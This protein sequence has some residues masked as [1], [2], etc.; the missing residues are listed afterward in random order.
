MSTF[1]GSIKLTGEEEYK[2]ALQTIT[3]NL[4]LMSST[5]KS[6]T[7][8]FNSQDKSI[9]NTAQA[10]KQLN[11]TI[12]Q[13]QQAI[14]VAK[15]SLSGYTIEMQKQSTIHNQLN[16][17]YKN[18]VLE[19][20]R[21]KK[22]SGETS[23]EYKKQAQ[24]VDK[25]EN[26]LIDSQI[27]L[28]DNKQAM[29]SLKKEISSSQKVI[30]DAQN[31]LD[32]LG[33]ELDDTEESA[34]KA[35]D[36]FTVFKGVVSDL[37]SKAIQGAISSV[38]KL[39][40][41]LIDLGK[42][43]ISNYADYEQL[44]GGV[45][46]LFKE[47]SDIVQGYAEQAY[48]TAGLSANEYMETVT[49][50]SASLLQGLGGDTK[51]AAEIAD[52]AIIDMSDNAN[53]MGTSMEMIQN[54]YQGFAKQNYTMLDN[55]KLGYG[56]T[57]TEMARL[58]RESGILGEAG[59]D[60][61]E[62]NLDQKVSYDQII[63]AIHQVQENM[64]ITG[65]TAKEASSTISGSVASMKASWQNLLTSIADDNK[66]LGKSIDEFIDSTITASQN[67]VPRVKKVVEGIK[68]LINTII[69][70]VFP[71]LKKEIPEL[72]PLIETFEWFIK[73]KSLVTGAIKAMI[74]AFAI[75][76]VVNFTKSI[77]DTG[78][79]LIDMTKSMSLA[80]TATT[81]NTTAQIANTTAQ[82]SGT[83][84]TKALTGAT[85]LLN[86]AW[87]ANPIGVVVAGVTALIAA[88]NALKGL[89]NQLS[90][91]EKKQKAIMEAQSKAINEQ[92]EEIKQNKSAWNELL[93][94]QKKQIDVGM[95]EISHLQAL[96]NELAGIVDENGKVKEGYEGRA[97]FILSTLNE[98][99]GTEY[100]MTGNIIDQYKN[101]TSSIDNV[102]DKKK[103][104]IIL[105]SQE[106][107]YSEAIQNQVEATNKLYEIEDKY[108]KRLKGRIPLEEELNTAF[109]NYNNARLT[110]N[111]Y[112]VAGYAQEIA[113]IEEKINAY[114]A[115]TKKL[116]SSRNAQLD[117]VEGYAYN[118]G[119]YEQNMALAHEGK[120]NEMTQVTWDYVKNYQ[121][122]G[123]A[124]K[125]MLE[126]QISDTEN[127]LNFLKDLKE[128]KNT[129][130]YD[131]QIADYEKQLESLQENLKKYN[132]ITDSE[133]DKT[134]IIWN[135][136]LDDQL[137]EIT[138]SKVEF[139]EDGKGNVQAYVDGIV[140][141]KPKS[142]EEMSKIVTSTINEISKQET[143]A[144]KAGEDLIDGVNNGIANERKQNGAFSAIANFGNKL[145]NRLKSSLKEESP[146][147]ATNQMGQ[148]LLEGL[149]LGIEKEENSVLK[150]VSNFGKSVI[151]SLNQGLS[152][153]VDITSIGRIK[154]NIPNVFNN[155]KSL[156]NTNTNNSFDYN[157]MLS[158]FQ[159]AL[160]S[161]K[162]EL[163]DEEAG[164]FVR[165]TVE[166]TIYT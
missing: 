153:N 14:N 97:S 110:G 30:N 82:A 58:V 156:N 151:S 29:S 88:Y 123:D 95:T 103:A 62:K 125:A 117:I 122:A 52:L 102:M 143:G 159:E 73:N 49:S 136:N 53:K 3:S 145:L 1:G 119:I 165:K 130:I 157:T 42:Q 105:N 43:S 112:A 133:L 150:Q 92:Y 48:K 38:K 41:T 26:E 154:N 118:I 89:T 18:A 11:D 93:E 6:Q 15:N 22:T 134:T 162:I 81:V 35:G 56:G 142:K 25:L 140:W 12:K 77:S 46:T 9:K 10:Q 75:T 135:D 131:S 68:K 66:D 5:L 152:E 47:S 124:E 13:Q 32:N 16:R 20:E 44:V 4:K 78:K 120:Y 94:S 67:L 113:K 163:D 104:Q 79:M 45:E 138:G 34:K 57:K 85:N 55:L 2:K 108:Q 21:I 8:D 115:D 98:A 109:T 141:G 61:T 100:T 50:F 116:E 90:E 64:G 87:K 148:F 69:T 63:M 101:L 86:A 144:K 164:R 27:R 91:E 40:G 17:E 54:A 107:L 70:D 37:T 99:L 147:K 129:E 28:D 33:K 127:Q 84:A 83:I 160:G 126:S 158:A 59:K 76:K 149:G 146:S 36:G 74:G 96:K 23:E 166:D 7:S 24:V 65:T 71:K 137:S 111:T 60:L 39:A 139:K 51:K 31:S 72:R 128:R 19:L 132:S 155:S 121:K 106:S 80:T 161:M 114:D